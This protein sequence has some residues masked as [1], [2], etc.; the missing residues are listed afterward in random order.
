MPA[1]TSRSP[2]PG[3]TSSTCRGSWGS[4][5]AAMLYGA[6]LCPAGH[7]PHKGGDRPSFLVSLNGNL[8]D[9]RNPQ[10]QPISPLVGLVGE[11]SGRTEGGATGRHPAQYSLVL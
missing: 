6:P 4:S 7:L 3:S 9:W 11:M 10:R 8:G 2:A 1:T 5:A